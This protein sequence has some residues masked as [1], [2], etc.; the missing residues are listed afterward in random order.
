V[1]TLIINAYHFVIILRISRK[2]SGINIHLIKNHYVK[3][4]KKTLCYFIKCRRKSAELNN[5]NTIYSKSTELTF[6]VCSKLYNVNCFD[7]RMR[8][9]YGYIGPVVTAKLK[10]NV[11]SAIRLHDEQCNLSFLVFD[12]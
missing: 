6:K 1:I 11:F 4:N 5:A 2:P 12:S 7:L 9:D 8:A 3:K 10:Q